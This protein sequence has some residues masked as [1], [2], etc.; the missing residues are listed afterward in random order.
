[1]KFH[2]CVRMT[3]VV[4]FVL[5]AAA[6]VFVNADAAVRDNGG[7]NVMIEILYDN[8]DR[9]NTLESA[10]GFSCVITGL[11]KKILFDC[12]G[13]G[14]I[15]MKNM[16]NRKV[17]PASIET[18]IISHAHWDHDGGLEKFLS[19]NS[20]VGV[21]L[22]GA[23]PGDKLTKLNDT[24]AE[25]VTVDKPLQIMK[26]VRLTGTMGDKIKE[27]SLIIDTEKGAVLV[28]GC[29]HPGIAEI[30]ERAAALTGKNVYM[31]IGGFH[32]KDK[33]DAEIED[34]VNRLKRSGVVFAAPSHCT[35]EKAIS[36]FR[37]IFGEKFMESGLGR[38]IEIDGVH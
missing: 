19:L 30:A 16:K 4:F 15:L 10:W 21:Y 31:I 29:S 18:V 8:I 7:E 32:L 26:N 2:L 25:A 17:D 9:E 28:C 5:A 38:K 34:I 11:E 37:R 22:P 1:M 35:G 23:Y 3:A 27:Q 12:G 24:G 36:T 14:D 33:T 20:K 6:M 13:D